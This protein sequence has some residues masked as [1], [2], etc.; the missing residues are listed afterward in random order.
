MRLC[1]SH[2]VR[3]CILLASAAIYLATGHA[4]AQP[5][6]PQSPSDPAV[7]FTLDFPGSTPSHYS[8]AVH[9]SGHASYESAVKTEDGDEEQMYRSEFE[10]SEESRRRIFTWAKQ[11]QYFQGK[12]DSGKKVAFT[13]DKVLSYQDGPR[14]S[15]SKYNYSV[16]EPV[17]ELTTW[18]QNMDSTLDFGRK[19]AYFH[20]YQKLALDDELKR[21][22]MQAKAKSLSE[23]QAIA[24]VLQE[25]VNDPSVLNGTRARARDL[26]QMG[27]V[28]NEG[29]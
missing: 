12:L 26:L 3:Q 22:D 13:G 11:S 21:M 7:T 6:S 14:S 4:A 28:T 5:T 8:I 16:L 24:P 23:I 2:I 25:I 15:T 10:V 27:S 19:L 9:I 1:L 18:F 17:Q 20:K 29:R